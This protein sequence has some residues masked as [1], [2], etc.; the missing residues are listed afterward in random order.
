MPGTVLSVGE[1]DME[2]TGGSLW[3][4][5]GSLPTTFASVASNESVYTKSVRDMNG[6]LLEYTYG[7]I[8]I[9]PKRD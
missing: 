2:M 8:H 7:P 1:R 3:I 4:A 9:R 6:L 5:S